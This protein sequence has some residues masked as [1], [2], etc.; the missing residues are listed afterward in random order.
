MKETNLDFGRCV[1]VCEC[2]SLASLARCALDLLSNAYRRRRPKHTQNLP[3]K[4]VHILYLKTLVIECVFAHR[5]S[6]VQIHTHDPPTKKKNE[7]ENVRNAVWWKTCDY[8]CSKRVRFKIN[9]KKNVIYHMSR[10][11]F[12][13]THFSPCRCL[14]LCIF[15]FEVAPVSL[16]PSACVGVCVDFG[17]FVQHFRLAALY[18]HVENRFK[19]PY[20]QPT[21][22][23][24]HAIQQ[25]SSQM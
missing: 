5:I 6:N 19:L 14:R 25:T 4:M 9:A 17:T 3:N 21:Q 16:W 18:R 23:H 10:G 2:L 1:R 13:L 24:T 8:N 20:P 15:L 11:S 22:T 7:N 12:I